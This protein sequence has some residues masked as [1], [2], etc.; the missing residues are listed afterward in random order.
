MGMPTFYMRSMKKLLSLNLSVMG[1]S[2]TASMFLSSLMYCLNSSIVLSLG[3]SICFVVVVVVE[4]VT[5]LTFVKLIVRF[6]F[7]LKSGVV[8]SGLFKEV[9][10][11]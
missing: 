5:C 11:Y 9:F 1:M 8:L 6:F 10:V 2:W 7:L 4:E 3:M